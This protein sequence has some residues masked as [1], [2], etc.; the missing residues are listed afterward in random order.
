MPIELLA[1]CWTHAGDAL[2]VPGHHLSPLDLRERAEAVA[3]AGFTGIGFTINDLEAAQATYGLPQ[4][5]RICDDLGL[6]HLEV[7]LLEDWWTTGSRRHTSD[8]IRRSLLD[9]RRSSRSATDQDRTRRRACRRLRPTVGRRRSLGGQLHELAAQ[10]T[11]VGT[12]SRWNRCRSPTSLT[13]GWPQASSLPLTI[14]PPVSWWTSGTWSGA[15]LPWRTWPRFPATRCS[16]WSSTMPRSHRPPTCSR[17]RFATGC[18]AARGSST[19][20]ASSRHCSRSASPDHGAS[21]SSPT[22]T[23]NG[24]CERH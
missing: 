3:T 13:S 17:T 15:P 19:S 12:R 20:P 7:E 21:R 18:C 22:Y 9:C 14:P 6:V 5:R 4:L 24:L 10:A 11:E 23:A 16:P 1:T 2:P 8:Q